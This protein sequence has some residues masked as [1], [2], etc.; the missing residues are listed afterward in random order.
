[1]KQ[2]FYSFLIE[3]SDGEFLLCFGCFFYS[4]YSTT[5]QFMKFH[6]SQRIS[7]TIERLDMY[8]ERREIT[9]LWQ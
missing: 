2:K 1:M 6:T 9:D 7:Q 4:Y 3:H 5:M 8:V